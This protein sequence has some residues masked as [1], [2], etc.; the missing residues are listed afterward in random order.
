MQKERERAVRYAWIGWTVL[1][2]AVAAIMIAGSSRSVVPNY[3]IAAGNW[4]AGRN[5]FDGLGVGGFTYLPHSALLFLPFA[6]LPE[7]LSEVLWRLLNII[8]FAAGIRAFG[9]LA[10]ERTEH[11]LFPLMSLVSIPLAW[12]CARNGQTTLIMA[13]LMLFAVVDIAHERRWR[14]ALWM[15]LSVAF[16]P[17]SIV[18]ILV[19]AAID[20]HMSWRVLIGMTVLVLFPFLTQQPAYVLQQYTG[21][22]QNTTTAAHVGAVEKGWTT[23]FNAIQVI[24]IR[25]SERIQTMIRLAAA[26][27]TL[28]LCFIA[29]R[30]HDAARSAIFVYSLAAAY[31]MLFSPRTENNTYAMLGPA[32]AVFLSAA[33]LVEKRILPAVLLSVMVLSMIVSRKIE[34]LM[35]PQAGTSWMLPLTAVCFTA[36]LV[37]RLFERPEQVR[38]GDVHP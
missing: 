12:S 5:L 9:R 4:L 27:G 34:H 19:V 1:F 2:A 33:Y 20:R 7:T 14:A 22:L 10:S 24:G 13:G 15:M 21:F 11:E 32:I 16:K 28:A 29:R 35:T 6:L 31:L 37:A 17:L 3:R 30:R 36:Y 38:R 23:L 18:L 25:V 8:V 26:V